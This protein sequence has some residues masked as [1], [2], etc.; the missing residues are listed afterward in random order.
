MPNKLAITLII[1]CYNEVANMQKGVLDKIG[2]FVQDSRFTEVLIVDDGSTDESRDIIRTYL[3]RY[4]KFRL[5]ENHHQGK[6]FAIITGIK[7]AK[8]T[9]VMFS[10]IDLATPI[11]EADKLIAEY[12]NGYDIVIGSRSAD[13]AGAPLTRKIMAYGLI[14]LRGLFL[15]LGRL[16]DTQ[17]GFKLFNADRAK[18]IVER[19][20][21]FKG[22]KDINGSSVSAGFD[23]EFLYVARKVG[24]KIAEVPVIWRHVETKNVNFIRDSFETLYDMARIK[25]Y[26]IKGE[27]V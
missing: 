11:E 1:P 10:D 15:G 16:K 6:A 21:V 3:K 26:G 24:C 17:C 22:G 9:V 5:I 13:R 14:M 19:L 8:G 2:N 12:E 18:D 7:E 23:L 27:Y 25:S 4:P 20:I